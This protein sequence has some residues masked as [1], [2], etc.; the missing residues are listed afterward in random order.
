[1]LAF[2]EKDFNKAIKYYESAIH[3]L[4]P[5]RYYYTE[6]IYF[7]ARFLLDYGLEENRKWIEIGLLLAKEDHY[8]YLHHKF[9]CLVEGLETPYNEFL[10]ILPEEYLLDEIIEKNKDTYY[11]KFVG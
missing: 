9:T 11:S 1:M 3:D 6:A 8:S 4:Q 2:I 7:Y 5:I 10:Y